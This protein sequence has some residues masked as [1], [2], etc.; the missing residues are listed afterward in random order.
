MTD[1]EQ[2]ALKSRRGG[3]DPLV[4]VIWLHSMEIRCTVYRFARRIYAIPQLPTNWIENGIE[5]I[6]SK[7][8]VTFLDQIVTNVIANLYPSLKNKLSVPQLNTQH[9]RPAVGLSIAL[10]LSKIY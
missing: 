7:L 4:K 5:L 2:W 1:S 10:A 8:N 6:D 9:W 3:K